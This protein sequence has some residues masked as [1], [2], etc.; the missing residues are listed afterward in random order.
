V[1]LYPSPAAPAG[2]VERI[3]SFGDQAF[4]L[5][6]LRNPEKLFSG[7]PQFLGESDIV[8]SILQEP[9]QQLT[10]FDKRS[11]MQVGSV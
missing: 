9:G 3:W 6:L 1:D 11:T 2:L 7:A 8:R 5:E 10:A 4:E